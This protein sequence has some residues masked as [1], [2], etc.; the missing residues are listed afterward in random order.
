MQ[1]AEAMSPRQPFRCWSLMQ[2]AFLAGDMKV[3]EQETEHL[4]SD[5]EFGP[6]AKALLARAK[7]MPPE[8]PANK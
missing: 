1:K 4:A 6:R 8:A 7:A 2:C 3:V 5:P